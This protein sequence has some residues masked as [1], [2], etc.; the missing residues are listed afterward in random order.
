MEYR[1]IANTELEPSVI[2]LGTGGFGT[3]L[4]RERAWAILDSFAE[5]GGNF[6]DSAHVYASWL[7]DGAG[8]SE[9]TLGAWVRQRGVR[10]RF[11]VGTKG[12]HPDL[13]TMHISRMSPAEIGH[14]LMES[15]ER[16]GMETIDIY[17]LHR[18]DPA[19]PVGEILGVLNEHMAAGR[20][21]AI[22]AS[23]WSVERLQE[24]EAYAQAHHLHTF[25]ASQIGYSL[26]EAHPKGVSMDGTLYMEPQ[27][28]Q[29]H[30]GI[31]SAGGRVHVAGHGLLFGQVWSGRP[32]D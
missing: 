4:P 21:R 32:R 2:C 26:A 29:F 23:N 11:I 19:V 31:A 1:K 14:D 12:A 18:D 17:W 20:I 27:I 30:T 24:A 6:A 3:A 9:R 22:G 16:L 10:D 15:L 13:K 7:P 25:C 5:A 28:W 8:A